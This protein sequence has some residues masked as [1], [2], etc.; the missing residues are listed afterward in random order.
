MRE[1]SLAQ[2]NFILV[3]LSL[4]PTLVGAWSIAWVLWEN[5]NYFPFEIAGA[6]RVPCPP[7]EVNKIHFLTD[8]YADNYFHLKLVDF[9]NYDENGFLKFYN[10]PKVQQKG[11][12]F[13]HPL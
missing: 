10:R 4:L 2:V 8:Y 3:F 13:H 12:G 7:N 5:V 1:V 9:L 11:T 6:M